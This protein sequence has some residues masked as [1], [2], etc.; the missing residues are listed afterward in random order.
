MRYLR[1]DGSLHAFATCATHLTTPKTVQKKKKFRSQSYEL[2]TDSSS[3]ASKFLA[4]I[5][6]LAQLIQ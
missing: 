6:V 4:I 3:I 1:V 5:Y 2:A